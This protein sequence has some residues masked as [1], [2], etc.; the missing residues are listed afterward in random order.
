MYDG[1]SASPVPYCCQ[2]DGIAAGCLSGWRRWPLRSWTWRRLR[3]LIFRGPTNTLGVVRRTIP[4]Q[5]RD[6][7][8]AGVASDPVIVLERATHSGCIASLT[9]QPIAIPPSAPTPAGMT[10]KA[11]GR[12]QSLHPEVLCAYTSPPATAPMT[13]PA[14]MYGARLWCS[15]ELLAKAPC[16]RSLLGKLGIQ[17]K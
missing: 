10:T 15:P 1:R 7:H 4:R 9:A 2:L 8:P 13:A 11:P 12:H 5:C 6:T 16:Q 3:P 17:I 14:M